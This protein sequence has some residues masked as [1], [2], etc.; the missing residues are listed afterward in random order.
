MVF[1][2]ETVR[3]NSRLNILKAILPFLDRDMQKFLSIYI[4]IQELMLTISFF[5]DQ[6]HHFSFYENISCFYDKI[7]NDLPDDQKNKIGQMKQMMDAFEMM[8]AMNAMAGA[9]ENG[10][11]QQ[12]NNTDFLMSFLSDDQKAM[13]DMFSSTMNEEKETEDL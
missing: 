10:E 4:L 5:Q 1:D 8:N 13:F 9:F 11:A 2:F 6:K 7:M 3:T 12:D